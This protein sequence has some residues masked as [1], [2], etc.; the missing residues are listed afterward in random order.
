MAKKSKLKLKVKARKSV[1]RGVK[2]G[3]PARERAL[4]ESSPIH[5]FIKAITEKKFNAADKYLVDAV[6]AKLKARIAATL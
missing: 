6:E 4:K 1:K 3:C 5:N 2:C